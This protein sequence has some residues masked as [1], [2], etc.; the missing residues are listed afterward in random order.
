[1]TSE[2]LNDHFDKKIADF[3]LKAL[4]FIGGI[5]LKPLA[6]ASD[7]FFRKNLGERYFTGVSASLAGILW[8][9]AALLGKVTE[10]LFPMVASALSSESL[11]NFSEWANRLHLAY[12]VG[13]I[14]FVAYVVLA[15]KNAI[16]S[17]KRQTSGEVWHSMSRG[18]VSGAAKTP[19][20]ISSLQFSPPRS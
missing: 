16:A 13:L 7:P 19:G 5:F 15:A 17:S 18:K 1:M 8:L 4:A 9:L 3:N 20:G 2:K 10:N 12:W 6:T 11:F 14:V